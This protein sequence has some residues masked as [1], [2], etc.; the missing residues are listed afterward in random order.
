M[1]NGILLHACAN[2]VIGTSKLLR[3]LTLARQWVQDG[4]QVLFV[5]GRLPGVML[6][7]IA[8][9]GC[10][11]RHL[12][13]QVG[14]IV[15]A[16]HLCK[17][18][19]EASCEWIV[20]DDSNP[21][22]IGNVSRLRC[23]DQKL[24]IIGSCEQAE[25]D[26]VSGP[27]PGFA[28]IRKNLYTEVPSRLANRWRPKRCLIDLSLMNGENSAAIIKTICRR[29]TGSGVVFDVVTPF[30][31]SAAEQLYSQDSPMREFFFWH[32][33]ADRAFQSLSVFALVISTDIAN[34]Y[35]TAYSGTASILLTEGTPAALS[36]DLTTLQWFVDRSQEGWIEQVVTM[37]EQFMDSPVRLARHAR[38]MKRLVDDQAALRI[39]T[40]I[41]DG[42]Q[43]VTGRVRSA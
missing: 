37:T 2:P 25:A 31:S 8:M 42:E 36:R 6:R 26:F 10:D 27:E 12:P 4:G 16:K 40:A 7:Q 35:E 9:S 20:L 1:E 3:S 19:Q 18:A 34:F 5:S 14:D 11:A 43:K 21:D 23:H 41:R 30:A 38:E 15:F 13:G 24:A 33:N 17:I 39:C 32:R 28:L 22:L 29:F